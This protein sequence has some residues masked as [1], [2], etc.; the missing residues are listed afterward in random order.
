MKIT[1]RIAKSEIH[2]FVK[3]LETRGFV[4][5]SDKKTRYAHMVHFR[6]GN[7]ERLTLKYTNNGWLSIF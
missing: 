5:T 4:K 7:N 6:K 1:Q 3:Q 2:L